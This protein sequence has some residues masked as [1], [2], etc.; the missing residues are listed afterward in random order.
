[1]KDQAEILR[2][3]LNAKCLNTSARTVAVISGKGGVGKSNFSLN[4]A[5]ELVNR[6][7]SVLL[8]DMDIG[9]GNIDI[10][11]GLSAQYSIADFFSENP[12]P[13]RSMIT[14][15][16]GG[17][18][19][20]AG[21]TG[22][23]T[24]PQINKDSF[25]SFTEE[26]MLLFNEYQYI[27]FDMPAGLNDTSLQFILSVD[28]VVV[29]TTTEPTSITD[30]YSAMKYI[31]L[32]NKEMPFYIIVNRAQNEKEGTEI[33]HRISK[34]LRHFLEKN[35]ILLGIIPDDQNIQ[36]AV[37]RQIPFIQYNV[38]SPS[39]RALIEL[40]ERFCQR[41]FSFEHHAVKTSF[42]TKLKRFLFER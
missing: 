25:F 37:K 5:I 4:F 11:S 21:G 39:S 32:E 23:S 33:F 29:V 31:I 3:K 9:M 22:L 18:H 17:I 13:L 38:K 42:A 10:L 34:V 12:V 41:M 1:M 28:E 36:R 14:E 19:F 8:F 2:E 6:G 40:T 26:F 7:N 35:V 27:I 20:I 15:L 16:P 24:F 30:A